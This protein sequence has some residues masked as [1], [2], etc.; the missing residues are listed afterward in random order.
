MKKFM[1]L[2]QCS[3]VVLDEADKMIDLGFEGDVNFIL[4]SITTPMKSSEE[5]RAELEER[6]SRQG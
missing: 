5:S 1:V 3:W 6:L 4:D 2:D